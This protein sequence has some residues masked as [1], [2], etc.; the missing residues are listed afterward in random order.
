LARFLLDT[1]AVSE[2]RRR[3]SMDSNFVAWARSVSATDFAIS[4][5]TRFELEARFARLN[6]RD[7]EQAARVRHWIDTFV[8]P[9]FA[10][11]TFPITE[12]IALRCAPMHVP[13]K[14]PV[15][16]SLI[17]ATALEH[18]LIVVTRNEADFSGLGVDL[19]NPWLA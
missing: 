19:L 5:L 12:A 8:T 7:P 4:V 2:F 14:R 17:A 1:N 3:D 16:D 11:A 13:D 6:R 18:R 15:I 10:D 9:T